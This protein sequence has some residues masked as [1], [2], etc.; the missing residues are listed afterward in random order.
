MMD[1]RLK[2]L[3]P[4]KESLLRLPENIFL[5]N[6][7][8][9]VGI[10]KTPYNKDRLVTDL[11]SFLYKEEH[12]NKI[13]SLL[14]DKDRLIL[15]AIKYLEQ[16]TKEM[17]LSF[18]GGE[19]SAFYIYDY[20]SNL[21]ERLLIY[22]RFDERSKSE[23]IDINPLLLDAIEK[24]VSLSLLI[25]MPEKM[26]ESEEK[27]SNPN[28]S[29]N[30]YASWYSFIAQ[31]PDSCKADGSF[32]KKI[33]ALLETTFY[34]ISP[35]FLNALN[36]ALI[37]LGLFFHDGTALCIN[38][39]KWKAFCEL[40]QEL[41]A[42]YV[43]VASFRRFPRDTLVK[44]ATFAK[45]LIETIPDEGLIK[46]SLLRLCFILRNSS[47]DALSAKKTGFF[48]NIMQRAQSP[49][50]EEDLFTDAALLEKM[51][52]FGL[53][54]EDGQQK[55]GEHI[56]KSVR[57]ETGS[58]LKTNENKSPFISI[59]A[60]F[61]VTFL[62]NVDLEK[63]LQLVS[64]MNIISF[65][66]VC[67]FEITRVSCMR[68][69]DK[70]ETSESI[71]GLLEQGS[72]SALSQNL[73]FSINEWFET[74]NSAAL[75]HGYVLQVSQDKIIQIE[76]NAVIAKRIKKVL[77]PG[78]YILDFETKEEMI[79]AV[80]KSALDFIGLPK[81]AIK[82]PDVLPYTDVLQKR[83][84]ILEYEK[85]STNDNNAWLEHI[86]NMKEELEKLALP[87][88]QKE[89]LLERIE[90]KVIITPKQLVG[91][92]VRVEKTEAS[93]IDFM[94]KIQV[95]EQAIL[96]SNMVEI[97][98]AS[99]VYVGRPIKLEKR[100]GDASIQ[101]TLEDTKTISLLIGQAR[102]IKRFRQPLY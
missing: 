38:E 10:I 16:P 17:I 95:I 102:N 15:S 70:G 14:S 76:N 37:N 3:N 97:Q 60:G 65:D 18:F 47:K 92:T 50:P 57:K 9:Y 20:I 90:R 79:A 24:E 13:L 99:G 91:E 7:R 21:E 101:L 72:G 43:C 44:H 81:N 63:M 39:K 33:L 56:L 86:E 87:I 49:Q 64:S 68:S 31:N 78:I 93:G 29:I 94:G 42:L 26:F 82:E 12:K 53:L 96:A 80:E 52:Y 62:R 61:S 22:K 35:E 58:V 32:K 59:N 67:R 28:L 98:S 40:S 75:Y 89:G 74:Y 84:L 30:L 71:L 77:A 8:M 51:V 85:K 2:D 23:Y 4:W 34:G 83:T 55:T 48:A 54:K 25:P 88:E 19:Y 36:T 100:E 5:N 45:N 6:V 27:E 11:I 73:V 46:N 69:F 66:T 1:E 41:Q